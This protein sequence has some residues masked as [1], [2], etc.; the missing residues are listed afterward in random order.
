MSEQRWEIHERAGDTAPVTA[1]VLVLDF[2]SRQK[3]R[4]LTRTRSGREVGIFLPRGDS[5]QHGD[6]LKTTCGA[7]I[8]VDAAE[9][10]LSEVLCDDGWTLA[11]AAY[12]LGNRHVPLQVLPDRLRYQSDYVLDDMIRQMGLSVSTVKAGFQPEKGAYHGHSH[13]AHAAQ[14]NIFRQPPLTLVRD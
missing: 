8:R 3:C 7:V 2:D 6:L 10:T 5:L 12:H 11:R 4:L 13:T 14:S 9:E 1:D